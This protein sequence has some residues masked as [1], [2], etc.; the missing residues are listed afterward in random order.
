MLH[1]SHRD[2]F[3][4]TYGVQRSYVAVFS[5]KMHFV[6]I[7]PTAF[8]FLINNLSTEA[9]RDQVFNFVNIH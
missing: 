1:E 8:C 3:L 7:V 5:A 4:L 2:F 9:K 6:T